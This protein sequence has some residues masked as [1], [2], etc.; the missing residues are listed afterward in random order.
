MNKKGGFLAVIA[1]RKIQTVGPSMSVEDGDI[2]EVLKALV[3]YR[4]H[5]D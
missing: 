5:S 4:R 3:V 2:G 1:G